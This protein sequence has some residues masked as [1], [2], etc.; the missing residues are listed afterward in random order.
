[1]T[2]GTQEA[3]DIDEPKAEE[4]GPPVTPGRIVMYSDDR[5][6][7]YPALVTHVFSSD[8]VNLFVFPDGSFTNRDVGPVTSIPFDPEGPAG[9]GTEATWRWPERV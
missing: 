9:G 6:G 1:M 4:Y 3:I 8:V 5:G 2:E 7:E